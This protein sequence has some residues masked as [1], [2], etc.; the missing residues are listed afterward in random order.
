MI[1][2]DG[3]QLIPI[4]IKIGNHEVIR[5]QDYLCQHDGMLQKARL[6]VGDLVRTS[7]SISTR[8][9]LTDMYR[10][11]VPTCAILVPRTA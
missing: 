10:T 4:P 6:Q 9:G 1:S 2:V 3:R 8:T 7:G 5:V 11:A